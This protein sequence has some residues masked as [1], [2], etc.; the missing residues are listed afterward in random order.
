MTDPLLPQASFQRLILHVAD[1]VVMAAWYQ[2]VFG[3]QITI[4]ERAEGWIELSAGGDMVVALHGGARGRTPQ[5]PKIQ[6]RV[7]DVAAARTALMDAG[8]VMGEA[9]RWRHLEWAEG[10]DP[11]GHVFQIANQ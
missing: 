7:A 8:I 3:W 4:D 5:W 6:V 10:A 1:P 11:E 9:Q 2:Q